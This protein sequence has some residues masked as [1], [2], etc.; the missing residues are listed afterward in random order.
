[1][2][3]KVGF[4]VI[5]SCMVHKL[6]VCMYMHDIYKDI[7]LEF[8]TAPSVVYNLRTYSTE[9]I[10]VLLNRDNN[11]RAHINDRHILIN[12]SVCTLYGMLR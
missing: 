11:I 5:H 9:V 8:A 3:H 4:V 6:H 7:R 1:M 2:W 12:A 10:Y